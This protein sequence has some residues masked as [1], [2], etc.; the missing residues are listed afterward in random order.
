[1]K[2][3]WLNRKTDAI[4]SPSGSGLTSSDAATR[5]RAVDELKTE[6][7]SQLEEFITQ[8]R[9]ALDRVTESHMKRIADAKAVAE[10][11]RRARGASIIGEFY[12]AADPLVREYMTD[13]RRNTALAIR[14]AQ[15]RFDERSRMELGTDNSRAIV[16]G[17]SFVGV[18]LESAPGLVNHFNVEHPFSHSQAL[19]I[20]VDEQPLAW[21]ARLVDIEAHVSRLAVQLGRTAP[22]PVSARLFEVMRAAPTDADSYACVSALATEAKAAAHADFMRT[23]GGPR[24]PAPPRLRSLSDPSAEHAAALGAQEGR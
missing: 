5:A 15:L 22:D 3:P 13:P 18:L 23:Y 8:Q 4:P 12:E 7:A 11:T 6:Q 17:L 10:A 20:V 24:L 19:T 9:K 16:V 21:C 14:D 2:I 1:M